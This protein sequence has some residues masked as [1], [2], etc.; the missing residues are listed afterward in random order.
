[1]SKQEE[2]RATAR[3]LLAENRVDLILGYTAGTLPL[4]TTP[5]FARTPAEADLLVWNAFCEYNLTNYLPRYTGNRVGIVVKGCDARSLV[6]LLQQNQVQRERLYVIGIPCAGVV[7]RRRVALLAGGAEITAA[8]ITGGEIVVRGRGFEKVLPM[9]EV[10]F[11]SCRRCR[12]GNPVLADVVLG[13]KVPERKETYEDL[14]ALENMPAVEREAYFAREMAKCIRCYACREV[15]PMCFCKQC[16]VD[17]TAPQWLSRWV[18][19]ADNLFFHLGRTMH[20][21]GRCVD[22]GACARACPVGV[23]LMAF[24]RKMIKDAEALFGYRAGLDP[25]AHLLLGTFDPNDPEPFLF[26]G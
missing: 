10:L 8:D 13:E 6:G 7:D 18:G 12:Y 15:C 22:C 26:R 3:R 25:E 24:N 2:L 23:D 14:A 19:T 16:F 11:P 20:L 5:F 21:V 1:M 4:R 17:G 9:E